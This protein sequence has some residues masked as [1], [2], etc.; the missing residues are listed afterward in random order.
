MLFC[1][2]LKGP[3]FSAVAVA[4][5]LHILICLSLPLSLASVKVHTPLSQALFHLLTL[6]NASPSFQIL[7]L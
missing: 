3:Y 6:M 7:G 4:F 2:Q 5:L 1:M